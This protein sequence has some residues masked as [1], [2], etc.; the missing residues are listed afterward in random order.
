MKKVEF[1]HT[2]EMTASIPSVACV[3]SPRVE[4]PYLVIKK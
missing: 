4:T 1:Y 3:V 2:T